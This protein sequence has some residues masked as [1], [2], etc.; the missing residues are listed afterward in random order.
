MSQK[1]HIFCYISRISTKTQHFFSSYGASQHLQGRGP[2]SG[3][4]GSATRRQKQVLQFWCNIFFA[5]N[6]FY[7]GSAS[8]WFETELDPDLALH[9]DETR[10][11]SCF[12]FLRNQFRILFDGTGS[13]SVYFDFLTLGKN[14]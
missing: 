9:F 10:S 2:L 1:V 3:S 5:Q 14:L 8:I 12:T 7:H 11:G 4:T 13:R 6:Y